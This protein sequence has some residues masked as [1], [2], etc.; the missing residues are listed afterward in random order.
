MPSPYRREE[1][2]ADRA[3]LANLVAG[4]DCQIYRIDWDVGYYYPGVRWRPILLVEN[5]R[6]I[7]LFTIF[8]RNL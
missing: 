5:S 3:G 7:L 1:L 4:Y 2:F 6:T 8:S